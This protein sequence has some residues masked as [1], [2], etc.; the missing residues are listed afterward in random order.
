M[1]RAICY[2]VK[3]LTDEGFRELL[4]RMGA[5]DGGTLTFERQANCVESFPD[6][7][8]CRS[9]AD[10]TAGL[11]KTVID[12]DDDMERFVRVN[13][14]GIWNYPE[15]DGLVQMVQDGEMSMVEFLEA[16]EDMSGDF[17]E[18]L[19]RERKE[20]T[21]ENAGLFLDEQEMNLTVLPPPSYV[22]DSNIVFLIS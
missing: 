13:R 16:Q 6:G 17:H 14:T 5:E 3:A 7:T 11:P 20:R 2:N 22:N 10:R 21:E 9:F 1:I 18:W 15:Y 19:K 12:C 8:L 4:G